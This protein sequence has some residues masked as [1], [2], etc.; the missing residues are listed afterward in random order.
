MS[1]NAASGAQW[2]D[3]RVQGKGLVPGGGTR[4]LLPLGHL[5]VPEDIVDEA[6]GRL[7]GA[8]AP[9]DDPHHHVLRSVAAK[10]PIRMS[11]HKYS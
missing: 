10:G 7:S 6:F 9:A 1:A 11:M 3:E 2:D 8:L 4:G 5:G